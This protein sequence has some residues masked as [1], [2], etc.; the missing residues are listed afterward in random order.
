MADGKK[1]VLI[2]VDDL[3]R[4]RTSLEQKRDTTPF[5]E[6]FAEDYFYQR[7]HFSNGSVSPSSFRTIFTSTYRLQYD[8]VDYLSDER[9]YLPEILNIRTVGLSTNPFVSE[10]YGFEKGYDKFLDAS[11]ETSHEESMTD[12]LER[13]VKEF[14]KRLPFLSWLRTVRDRVRGRATPYMEGE[15]VVRNAEQLIE[16]E[17]SDEDT[18]YWFH[19][20]DTHSPFVPPEETRGT[21][22]NFGSRRE[23]WKNLEKEEPDQLLEL[24]D[25][26]MLYLDRNLEKLVKILEEKFEEDE[27]EVLIT[28]DH[29]ELFYD[30]EWGAHGHPNML[31]EELFEVPLFTTFKPGRDFSTHVDIAPTILEVFDVDVPEGFQG[32][33]L[34]SQKEKGYDF[35]EANSNGNEWLEQKWRDKRAAKIDRDG[36]VEIVNITRGEEP[37]DE[38]L[39]EH[40]ERIGEKEGG[41]EDESDLSE[42]EEEKVKENLRQ[43]GYD[44]KVK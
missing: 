5:L 35:I 29:G 17:G 3:R 6:E 8:D 4:D 11:L 37:E 40:L 7:N 43:L 14:I 21:W 33:S 39:K 24:Y 12:G 9:P 1:F 27:F 41:S 31:K 18:F 30:D 13:S 32:L 38:Y 2:T 16:N 26:C 15:Q 20:M 42:E 10:Y 34:Y 44:E 22:S 25:E 36:I 28:S 19:F 23:V